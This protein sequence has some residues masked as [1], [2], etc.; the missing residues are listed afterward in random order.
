MRLLVSGS[1]RTVSQLASRWPERLGHLLT[2]ANRNSVDS[3]LATG[4]AWAADNGAYSG[5]DER[6]FR[7]ML[8]RITGVPRCLFVVVPDVVADARATLALFGSWALE[9]RATGQPL[10]FVGQDG[11][12]GLDLPWADFDCLFLGGSTEW[13]LS[14]A[15]HD[16]ASAAKALGK[17]VHMGRVNS[18][19]RLRHAY[20]IGCDTVDGSSASMYGDKYIGKFCGWIESLNR[21]RTI[22]EEVTP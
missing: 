22:L 7:R 4:L 8:G 6:R 3:L 20:D 13:K 14:Q 19:Q 2:P 15:A 12:E 21:Q 10:A 17:H 5:L 9:C 11:A 18:L 1:T 16:L